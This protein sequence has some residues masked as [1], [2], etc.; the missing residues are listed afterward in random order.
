M[1]FSGI[2]PKTGKKKTQR[3]S[4]IHPASFRDPSGS[5]FF[6]NGELLRNVNF[7]YKENYELLIKSGLYKE[8]TDNKLLIPHK[9]LKNLGKLPMKSVRILELTSPI[10]PV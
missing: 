2:N 10:S 3:R 9:T 5:L 1:Y 4:S 7:V 8:L 6:K